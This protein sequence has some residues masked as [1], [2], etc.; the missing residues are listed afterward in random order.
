MRKPE[1]TQPG[2][3]GCCR[4]KD[5]ANQSLAI[6]GQ[7]GFCRSGDVRKPNA[8][9]SRQTFKKSEEGLAGRSPLPG[10]LQTPGRQRQRST[11]RRFRRPAGEPAHAAV[12]ICHCI[13]E[14]VDHWFRVQRLLAAQGVASAVNECPLRNEETK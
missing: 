13:A 11:R 14:T 3:S 10:N 6:D 5:N 8:H 4:K 9:S 2:R 7:P 12:L 1:K